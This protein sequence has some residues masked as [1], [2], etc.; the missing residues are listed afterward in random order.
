MSETMEKRLQVGRKQGCDVEKGQDQARCICKAAL[1]HRES[2]AR[3]PWSA[4]RGEKLYVC[5]RRN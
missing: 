1:G 3:G 4:G 2:R 5:R